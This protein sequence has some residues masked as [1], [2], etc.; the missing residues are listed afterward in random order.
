MVTLPAAAQQPNPALIFEALNAYQRSASLKAAIE[1]DLFTAIDDGHRTSAEIAA[2]THC[3]LRGTRILCDYLVIGGFLT[4]DREQYA[5]SPEA[6]LF[7]NRHSPA[8]FGSVARFLLDPRITAPYENLAEIVRIGRTTLPDQGTVSHDNPLWI[9]F[10]ND[11]APMVH[12]AASEIAELIAGDSEIRVL[13][14]AAGHGLFGIMVARE[15][16]KAQITALDWPNVLA[17]ATRTP[18]NSELAT[19]TH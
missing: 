12:P 15:N 8:Y 14:I 17:V 10:A 3:S 4:K 6:A 11:I 5:L 16:P 19:G 7:L 1:L 9:D 2:A 13:D 18:Q